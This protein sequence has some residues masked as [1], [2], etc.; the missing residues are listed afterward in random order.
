V[1]GNVIEITVRVQDKATAEAEAIK[2][3][4]HRSFGGGVEV[5]VRFR[6]E[7][8]SPHAAGGT[9]ES[10]KVPIEPDATGFEE[11]VR[12]KTKTEKPEPVKVPVEPETGGFEAEFRAAMA[13]ADKAGD[14]AARS[15]RGSFTSMESGSRSLRAAMADLEP[16]AGGAGEAVERAGARASSGGSS[17]SG[18]GMS[19]ASLHLRMVL[20]GGAALALAPAL[21]AIPAAMGAVAAG[22]A[23]MTFGLGGVITAL[24]DYGAQSQA[25]GESSAQMALTAFNNAVAIRNAEQAISDAKHQAAVQAQNSADAVASAQERL[26]TAQESEQQATEALNQ[27][28]KDAVNILADLNNAS[29]DATNSVA[30]AQL[31][32]QQAQQDANKTVSSSLSTDLQKAQAL[33][34]VQDA[35]Q[36]LT[37]AQQHALEAQQ[38]ADDANAKGVA[39]STQVVQAQRA[40]AQAA[41]GVADAQHALVRA[42]ENAAESQRQSAEQVQKAVQNLSDTYKQQGLAAAAAAAS[43]SSAANKFQQDMANLTPAGQTFVKQLISMRDGAKQLSQTAQTAML[44]GLTSMLK[45]SGPLLPIFN[46]ALHDL[47]SVVG[48]VATQ[49]GKLFQSPAF[50]G[51]LK[52]I[53]LDGAT[54][55]GKLGDALTP[56]FSGITKAGAG[57]G[58]ILNGFATGIASIMSSGLPAFL[59]GLTSNAPGAGQGLAAIGDGISK[60]MGPIGQLAGQL[61]GALGPALVTLAPIFDRL[62]T[63]LVQGLLPAITSGALSSTLVSLVQIFGDMAKNAEPLISMMGKSLVNTLIILNPLLSALAKFL[64]SNSGWMKDLTTA[65]WLLTFPVLAV[66]SHLGDLRDFIGRMLSDVKKGFTAAVDWVVTEGG[67]LASWVLALPGRLAVVGVHM[68]SWLQDRWSDAAG[69][70]SSRWDGLI[71]DV[72]KLPGRLATAGVHMWDFIRDSFKD[73]INTVIRWWDGLSFSTPSISWLGIDSVTIGMP[74]ISTFKAAGGPAGGMALVGGMLGGLTAIGEQGGELMKLPNGTQIWPHANTVSALESGAGRGGAIAVQLEWVGGNAGDEF[75]TWLRKN[76]RIRGGG[77]PNG[78]Q[79]VLGQ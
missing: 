26:A 1:S 55:A 40:Q 66:M 59:S 27:A 19:F 11:K 5:P 68:W 56:M 73:S 42:Q 24:K 72:K 76:I 8:D 31:A 71:D 17:A 32:L 37:D 29:A 74:Q 28:W 15:L 25:A 70:V 47:G 21:A 41:Q 65:T 4:L 49:F 16:A 58:P 13:E 7:G 33:Q 69:W 23:L 34:A 39:G 45:D 43:G 54:S 10:V 63:A 2:Q 64:G 3:E 50:Q 77:G 62:V 18:A 79:R 6:T 22:G 30:D 53:F 67:R 51:D 9:P 78:V 75:M 12:R 20:L 52:Q 46:Q 38:S 14:E 48:G 60:A 61:A 57:A 35:Q 44:P 36:H